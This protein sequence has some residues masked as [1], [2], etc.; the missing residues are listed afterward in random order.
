MSA[1]ISDNQT[2]YLHQESI[3]KLLKLIRKNPEKLIKLTDQDQNNSLTY[4]TPSTMKDSSTLTRTPTRFSVSTLTPV[5]RYLMHSSIPLTEHSQCRSN[6]LPSLFSLASIGLWLHWRTKTNYLA[7]ST[8]PRKIST[9]PRPTKS[10][11]GEQLS[12]ARTASD[13]KNIPRDHQDNHPSSIPS[14]PTSEP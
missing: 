4:S 12:T 2:I 6:S 10:F 3:Q 9:T 8:T 7:T 5:W 11:H 13:K 14:L 1:E